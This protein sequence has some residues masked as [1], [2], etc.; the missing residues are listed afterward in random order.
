MRGL[1][2]VAITDHNI[3]PTLGLIEEIG[4]RIIAVPGLEVKTEVGHM[5]GLGVTSVKIHGRVCSQSFIDHV[6]RLGGIVVLAHPNPMRIDDSMYMRLS[7]VDCVEVLNASLRPYRIAYARNY[8]L[9]KMMK[10]SQL[11]GS[12][13]HVPY[14]I[15]DA[16]TVIECNNLGWRSIVEAISMK[17]CRPAGRASSLSSRVLR[18]LF[19]LSNL[20]S[21]LGF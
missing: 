14:T 13:S 11:G 12:D 9:A 17:L 3:A 7:K 4:R 2:G 6:H 5:I 20:S 10:A 18:L 21:T 1:D 15:G 8:R 19:R 16:Y